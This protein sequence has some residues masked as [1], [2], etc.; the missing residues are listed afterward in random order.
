MLMS[1]LGHQGYC[2]VNTVL[3]VPTG[4]FRKTVTPVTEGARMRHG[5]YNARAG[6]VPTQHVGHCCEDRGQTDHWIHLPPELPGRVPN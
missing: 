1:T 6:Q 3:I 4:V 2:L 5:P